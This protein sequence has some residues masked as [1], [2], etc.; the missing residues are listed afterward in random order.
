[1][2]QGNCTDSIG[3]TTYRILEIYLTKITTKSIYFDLL[4]P[5][6]FTLYVNIILRDISEFIRKSEISQN[7]N[8]LH[9]ICCILCPKGDI[10]SKGIQHVIPHVMV[11]FSNGQKFFTTEKCIQRH[12][13]RYEKWHNFLNFAKLNYTVC[14]NTFSQVMS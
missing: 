7:S 13:C 2:T 8:G 4:N 9:P 1:M 3:T 14:D 6:D 10:L 5:P 12:V 11:T